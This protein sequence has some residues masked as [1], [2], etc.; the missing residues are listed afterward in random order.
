MSLASGR[1]TDT[2][3]AVGNSSKI[4]VDAAASSLNRSERD[5]DNADRSWLEMSL[6]LDIA[7]VN[8]EPPNIPRRMLFF[9]KIMWKT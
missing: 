2:I 7:L 9:H 1:E 8:Q 5:D 3:V 4:L 6:S